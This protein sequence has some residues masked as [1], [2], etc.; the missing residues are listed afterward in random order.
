MK[1]Q[2]VIVAVGVLLGLLATP[3]GAVIILPTD[4]DTL[5]LGAGNRFAGPLVGTFMTPDLSSQGGSAPFA[6]GTLT[7]NVYL[8]GGTFTYAYT[9]NPGVSNPL[10]FNTGFHVDGFTGVAGYSFGEAIARG[11]S[12]DPTSTLRAARAFVINW[13]NDG[14]IDS[15]V[16]RAFTLAGGF[17]SGANAGPLTF[18]FQSTQAPINGNSFNLMNSEVGTATNFATSPVPEPSSLLLVGSGL[19]GL[20]FWARNRFKFAR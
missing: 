1:K 15:N 4:F 2:F 14:T 20:G 13:E 6:I 19:V 11:A 7:G 18:F 3:A 9:V 8:S 16:R 10:E 5:G 17:W 12:A